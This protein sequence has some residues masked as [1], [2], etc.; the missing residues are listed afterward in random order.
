MSLG[1]VRLTV[2][3]QPKPNDIRNLV[4]DESVLAT[5]KGTIATSPKINKNQQWLFARFT[6]KDAASS[7]YLD[8]NEAETAAG[9]AKING[10]I[11]VQIDEPVLDLKVGDYVKIYCWLERFGQPKNPGQFNVADF[12]KKRNVIVAGSVKSRDGIELLRS[13]SSNTLTKI[14]QKVK[15]TANNVLFANAELTNS[16]YGLLEALLL[17][18][19]GN[20]DS[21]TYQAFRKTGLLHFISLSGMHLGIL[22]G[23]VWWL[24]KTAGFMKP[25]RA[26]ICLIVLALFLLTVQLRAPVIR[27][28]IMC[29]VFCLATLFRRRSSPLNT[30]C[31]AAI[32]L[33][34]IRPT[35]IFEPGWQLSFTSVL[36][37]ILFYRRISS[38]LY[39]GIDRLWPNTKDFH[40]SI[41]RPVISFII[42]VF[43]VGLAAWLGSAGILLYHFYTINP[44]TCLW[45][46]FAFPFVGLILVL[47]YLKIVLGFVLQ[48]LGV[49]LGLLLEILCNF[50]IGIVTWMAKW[51]TTEILIGKVSIW[52][53]FC[54]YGLVIFGRFFHFR[55]SAVKK[56]I[57]TIM[58]A[59]VLSWLTV[60]KWQR[61]YRDKLVLTALDVGHGQAILA[62]LPGKENVLFDAGSLFT[63]DVG[64]RIVVPFLNYKGI[65]RIDAVVISHSD[66]DHINGIP[67]IVQDGRVGAVYADKTFFD[68][69][70]RWTVARFLNNHLEESG[71]KIQKIGRDLNLSEQ[72]GIKMIWPNENIYKDKKLSDNDKSLVLL[73]QFADRK[74]LLCSDIERY[75]QQQILKLFPD[76]KADIVTVPHHGSIRTLDKDFLKGLCAKVLLISNGRKDYDYYENI[77]GHASIFCTSRDGAITVCIDK[78]GAIKTDTF[79]NP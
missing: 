59:A 33:L 17:G 72:A 7:F 3:F 26:I 9:F 46:V 70:E 16:S 47:G 1:A 30:L 77:K 53:I 45:T 54:Y 62:Q 13:D 8:V 28:S 66:I 67:E 10:R 2:Y 29:A 50:L 32:I 49:V 27:A 55:Q 34:L 57:C 43:A 39:K 22:I 51:F 23:I 35:E 69:K 79:K 60:L 52:G 65:N 18:Y 71:F 73:M 75:A 40:H 44:F 19:R 24:C 38:F 58:I 21:S 64:N 25:T 56:I 42:D 6:H 41:L 5:I 11:R 36:G 4:A 74:I 78:N 31:L 76:I 61:T 37:I 68:D 15:Q 63:R 48:S 12:L 14:R 20:I